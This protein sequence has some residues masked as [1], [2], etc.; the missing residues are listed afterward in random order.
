MSE[1]P[2]ETSRPSL[3]HRLGHLA[4]TVGKTGPK[5][6]S[7]KIILQGS[8][9]FLIFG[10]LVFTVVT[11]WSELKEKGVEFD[12]IWLLT[13]GGPIGATN[14]LVI[15]LYRRA[16]VLFSASWAVLSQPWRPRRSGPSHCWS[17]TS[18]GRSC[19][20]SPGS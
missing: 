18:R 3:L 12:L 2:T 13:Q 17:G 10:F 7:T 6:K 15:D 5:K 8:V 19:T 4:A 20:C 14:T 9:A 1:E 11:Q 16:F